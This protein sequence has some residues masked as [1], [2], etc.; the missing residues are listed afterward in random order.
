MIELNF[1]IKNS[2]NA[3]EYELKLELRLQKVTIQFHSILIIEILNLCFW[4]CIMKRRT[5]KC[6]IYKAIDMKNIECVK[7]TDSA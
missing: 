1:S 2:V 5:I 6:A 3:I 4:F 7:D